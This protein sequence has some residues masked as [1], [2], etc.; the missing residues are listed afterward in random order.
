M[1]ASEIGPERSWSSGGHVFNVVTEILCDEFVSDLGLLYLPGFQMR[2]LIPDYNSSQ[3]R[4]R[5]SYVLERH[6]ILGE[7]PGRMVA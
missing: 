2:F 5:I 7:K 3:H 6:W 1:E 4:V